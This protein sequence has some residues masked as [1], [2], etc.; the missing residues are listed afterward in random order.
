MALHDAI[1]EF[2]LIHIFERQAVHL[3]D[4]VER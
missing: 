4:L 1:A 2:L 3:H